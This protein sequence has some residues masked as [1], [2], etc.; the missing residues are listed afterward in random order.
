MTLHIAEQGNSGLFN[1]GSG[2]PHTWLDLVR[3]IF[4]AMN[5]AENIEFIDMPLSLR[6]KYQY[7]TI[8]TIDRLRGTG[9]DAAITP[10]AEAV[11]DYVQ[12][13]LIPDRR[14]DPA[15]AAPTAVAL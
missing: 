12:N 2:A 9:Y 7:C 11:D 14:L 8:A 13:Y 3:P 6:D 1:V 10:L 4:R 5:V 15:V